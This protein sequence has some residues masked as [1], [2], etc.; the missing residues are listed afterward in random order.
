MILFNAD[1][2]LR[3]KVV[4]HCDTREKAFNLLQWSD[5]IG[6]KWSSKRGYLSNLRWDEFKQDTCYN[7]NSGL[8][9]SK[10]DEVYS[11]SFRILSYDEVLLVQSPLKELYN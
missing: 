11:T 5:S 10:A 9:G 3:P 4:V 6:R 2:I 7:I 1:L 8:Y